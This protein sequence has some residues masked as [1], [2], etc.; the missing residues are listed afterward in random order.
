[1]GTPDSHVGEARRSAPGEEEGVEDA[2]HDVTAIEVREP[3]AHDVPGIE[4]PDEPMRLEVDQ[5]A[6]PDGFWIPVPGPRGGGLIGTRIHSIVGGGE[7]AP[8]DGGDGGGVSEK[9]E[10]LELAQRGHREV[11]GAGTA[12]RP[13]DAVLLLAVVV[14]AGC[15]RRSLPSVRAG[16]SGAQT[17]LVTEL[18]KPQRLHASLALR[19]EG[20]E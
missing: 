12:A 13:G 19:P 9:A 14:Q 3:V 6:L 4:P 10:L 5:E 17:T 16:A 18:H 1:M 20:S 11:G 7:R 15:F 8:G 2:R